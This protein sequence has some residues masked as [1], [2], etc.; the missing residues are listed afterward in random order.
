MGITSLEGLQYC[1]NLTKLEM[2]Y[3]SGGTPNQISISPLANLTKLT[4]LELYDNQISN[5]SALANLTQL[6]HLILSN[7]LIL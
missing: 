3:K 4:Y 6:T 2:G 7:N 1:T 5:I